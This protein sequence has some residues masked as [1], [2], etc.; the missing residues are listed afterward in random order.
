MHHD[1]RT[2]VQVLE[3]VDVSEHNF[4]ASLEMLSKS[5]LDMVEVHRHS[6][7]RGSAV[8]WLLLLRL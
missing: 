1:A 7:M 2:P 6:L 5:Y 3:E 4:V 8:L